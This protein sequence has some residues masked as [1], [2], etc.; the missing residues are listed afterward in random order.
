MSRKRA[1]YLV[2]LAKKEEYSLRS[3]NENDDIPLYTGERSKFNVLLKIM[4]V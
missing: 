3:F 2:E 4:N 1:K